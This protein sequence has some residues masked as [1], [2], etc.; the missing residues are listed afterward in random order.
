MH[1]SERRTQSHTPEPTATE[2][3]S[4]QLDLLGLAEVA[5]LLH[6][7]KGALGER[8]R[9]TYRPG[10]LIPAFPEPIITLRCGPVWLREQ[11]LVYDAECERLA[12]LTWFQ[13]VYGEDA[14]DPIHQALHR[15]RPQ[16]AGR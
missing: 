6:L 9:R 7:S 5:K 12:K 4:D 1:P 8:R 10:D 3:P 16:E 14:I 13:R 15:F 11:I 2:A